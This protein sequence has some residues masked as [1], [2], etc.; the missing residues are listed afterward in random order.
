VLAIFTQRVSTTSSPAASARARGGAFIT[1]ICIHRHLGADG[2]RV[3]GQ[4]RD[5]RA[6]AEA[7]HHIHRMGMSRTDLKHFSPRISSYMGFT[8]ITR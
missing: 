7:V 3:L 1:P 4:R 8:G 5:L 2:D 6:L